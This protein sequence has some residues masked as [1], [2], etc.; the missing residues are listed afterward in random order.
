M[1]Q[2]GGLWF[3]KFKELKQVDDTAFAD[4]IS[5]LGGVVALTA[6]EKTNEAL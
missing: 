2:A 5:S 6:S 4:R 3:E 1:S